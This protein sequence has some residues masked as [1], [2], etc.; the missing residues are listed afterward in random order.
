M[1]LVAFVL[2]GLLGVG[3]GV[4]LRSQIAA[5]VTGAVAYIIGTTG[6]QIVAQIVYNTWIHEKWVLWAQVLWPSVASQVM[7][8]P[9]AFLGDGII[10]SPKWWVGLL[11]LVGY[12]VLF[13]IIGTLIT[14]KRDI[15]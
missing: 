8:T 13:G 7:I 2:W 6:V 9:D 14:R 11:V 12:G 4:L 1:N 5:V 10:E 3:L 15:A